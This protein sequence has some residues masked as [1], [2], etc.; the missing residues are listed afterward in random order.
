VGA[1]NR[2]NDEPA[3]L[4]SKMAEREVYKREEDSMIRKKRGKKE[5][6]ENNTSKIFK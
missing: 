2:R 6:E 3:D 1:M 5:N 4:A